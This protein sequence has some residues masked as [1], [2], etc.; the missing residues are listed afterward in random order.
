MNGKQF[1][2]TY[3]STLNDE[4]KI[5]DE[6]P[7]F[8]NPHKRYSDI[9]CLNEGDSGNVHQSKNIIVEILNFRKFYYGV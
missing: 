9:E 6:V 2:Y 1:V 5:N 4:V 7:R 3:Y 8:K